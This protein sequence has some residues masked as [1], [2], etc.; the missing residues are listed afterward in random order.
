VVYGRVRNGNELL[1]YMGVPSEHEQRGDDCAQRLMSTTS[2]LT[3]EELASM[4]YSAECIAAGQLIANGKDTG[5]LAKASLEVSWLAQAC[6]H[7]VNLSKSGLK[8]SDGS[9]LGKLIS[10]SLLVSVLNLSNNKLGF[11]AAKDIALALKSNTTITCVD[12][13]AN[14]LGADGG[15]AIAASIAENSTITSVSLYQQYS[16]EQV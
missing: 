2:P 6:T 16:F 14:S 8:E 10:E 13:S 7:E 5:A 9:A 3:Q 11:A 1:E 12:V 15:R 4:G